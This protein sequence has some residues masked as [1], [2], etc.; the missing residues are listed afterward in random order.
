[1]IP[2]FNGVVIRRIDAEVIRVGANELVLR[3]LE[4]ERRILP[5]HLWTSVISCS[6][7]GNAIMKK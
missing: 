7:G 6:D 5:S 1:V 2:A 3:V 4:K